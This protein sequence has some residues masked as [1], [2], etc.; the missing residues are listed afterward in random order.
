MFDLPSISSHLDPVSLAKNAMLAKP[1]KDKIAQTASDFE[2][3]L[4][5]QLFQS[6]RKTIE[7][8]GLFGE[9]ETSKS[10]YEYLLDNAVM[11]Q[12][13]ANGQTWGLAARLEESWTALQVKQVA[14]APGS[15]A[16]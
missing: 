15:L 9:N 11:Q 12:A 2:A 7:P 4:M 6:M 10:T 3:M 1:E 8:S 14:A 13:V 16:E 5:A